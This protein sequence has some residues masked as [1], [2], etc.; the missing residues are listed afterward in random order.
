MA[1][2]N[3]VLIL[4]DDLGFSDVGCYGGEVRTPNIDRLAQG[5]LRFSQFYNTARCSPSRASLLTGLHPHQTGIGVLTNDDR[6]HGYPGTINHRCVTAAEVL[7]T[8]GYATGLTGKW[9]LAT[10][11]RTPN[12]AWPTRRGF[13]Y[14][15]GTLT[16]CGSYFHPGTLTRGEVN[17]ENEP[18]ES[19]FYYTEAIADEASAFIR[20]HGS[21]HPEQP[22]FLYV[23]FTAPH[24][25]LHARAED[26]AKYRG[27]FDAGWDRLREQRMQRLL[28][29]GILQSESA[30]LSERDPTQPPWEAGEHKDWQRRRMEAYAAQ[31]D[32]MDQ[33]IG[34]IL[35][36]LEDGSH[37]GNTLVIFL[38][39]N[40]ASDETLPLGKMEQFKKRSDIVRLRARDGR[41][42]RIGNDP[43]IMPGTEDT[44][45]SYGRA[46]ANLSN[47][48]F[49][50]YKRWVHEGGIATPFIV[51]WPDGG[52]PPGRIVHAPAQ[53]TDVLPT[54]LDATGAGY[55]TR[56]NGH[57]ILPYEGDSLLPVLRGG[58]APDHGLYWEHTGNAAIRGGTWKLVRDWPL[59]WE[60]YDLSRD[61]S[62]IHDLADEHPE[63]VRELSPD[64][65][66][67]AR[68]VG[69]IPWEVTVNMYLER[70]QTEE[71]ARA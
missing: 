31:V 32:R 9:H 48:P 10:D 49:R 34:R 68:R 58:P 15:Y 59:P 55:P 53:L 13:D 8:A 52:L 62:E 57:E 28:D 44:Y 17:V 70:G 71:E 1:A 26:V 50:Y 65:D 2:P 63:V 61:R 3:V 51:H 30:E 69:V 36:A 18:L 6:P 22:F 24:W 5:G 4:A 33:G 20:R 11:M 42:V 40:G 41:E 27:A 39:D 47:T 60:V 56:Y 29:L 46:W 38:S 64:W 7:K 14:F 43:S 12:D 16:G 45:A 19:D 67:W 35:S 37:L 25:P 54:I 66:A 21:S 23:A